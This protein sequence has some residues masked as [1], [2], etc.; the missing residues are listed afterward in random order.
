[1]VCAFDLKKSRNDWR[2]WL[3]V[4]MTKSISGRTGIHPRPKLLLLEKSQGRD[5][6]RPYQN[7]AWK[8]AQVQVRGEMEVS[9]RQDEG[10][11]QFLAPA[12]AAG[13]LPAVEGGILATRTGVVSGDANELFIAWQELTVSPA[14]LEARLYV[15][16]DG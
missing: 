7:Q 5:G 14:G 12:V 11:S 16:Q 4:I 6:T 8:L 15:S 13:I 2:I 3:L 1:M 10:A 9:L